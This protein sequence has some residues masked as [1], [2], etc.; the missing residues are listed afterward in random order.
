MLLQDS[1]GGEAKTLMVACVSPAA[2]HAAESLSTLAFASKVAARALPCC[3]S[4]PGRGGSVQAYEDHA[5]AVC[6][7]P[8]CV[9]SLVRDK[10]MPTP[11]RTAATRL[12][13]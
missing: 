6:G 10:L 13:V 11:L 7:C 1:L 5:R 8:K 4:R 9:C 3:P 12:F 2:L